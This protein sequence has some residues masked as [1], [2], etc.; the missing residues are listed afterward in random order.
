[1]AKVLTAIVAENLSC[2]VE[3]HHLLP[4]THFGGRPGR[5]TVDAVHYLVHKISAAWRDNKVASVLFLDVEGAFPNAVTTKLI[6]N[7]KKRRIPTSIVNF[8]TLLLTN[9]RTR[10]KFDDHVSD[11]INILNGIGQGD[12]LS[13][14][15]YILYNADLLDLPDNP[16]AEDA[17]G[18]VDDIALLSIGTDFEETTQRLKDMMTKRDGGLHWSISH[19]SKFEVTKSVIVHF[20]R[21]Q[22]QIQTTRTAAYRYLGRH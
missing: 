22:F 4:K 6:H 15:L 16:L 1:M 3:Q 2:I 18:Y 20:T 19:N 21:K 17:I 10:L 9:R 13:M 7:L 8:V 5:S 12:P 11:T 14:L